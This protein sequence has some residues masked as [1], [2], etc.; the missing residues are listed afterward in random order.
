MVY[1]TEAGVYQTT[2]FSSAL[3]QDVLEMDSTAV[4]TYVT[5]AI[6]KAQAKIKEDINLPYVVRDQLVL[7]S[8]Y[9]NKFYLGEVDDPHANWQTDSVEDN[10][11]AVKR[12]KFSGQ[13]RV[14]PYPTDCDVY[15]DYATPTDDGWSGSNATIT[16]DTVVTGSGT[17]SVKVVFS[18]AGYV[19]FPSNNY[20]NKIINQYSDNFFWFRTSSLAII[21]LS[22]ENSLFEISIS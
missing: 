19:Q 15:T 16:S 9:D 4:T 14:L 6:V 12:V 2:Q 3:I 21:H 22:P 8:G 7:G 20:F 10:L 5:A 1:T 18:A 11:D 13:R 17:Y